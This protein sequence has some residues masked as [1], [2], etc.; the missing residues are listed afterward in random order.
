MSKKLLEGIRIAD[1]TRQIAGPLA[2]KILANYGAEVMKIEG[3]GQQAVARMTGPFRDNISGVNR[4]AQ[5]AQFNTGKL[6]TNTAAQ[7]IAA[8]VG[9]ME[10]EEAE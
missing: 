9:H 1:F 10:A 7:I 5:F 6:S 8:A 2:T 4:G 3:T